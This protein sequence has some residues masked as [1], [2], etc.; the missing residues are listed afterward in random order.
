MPKPSNDYQLKL[1][2]QKNLLCQIFN[3][4][5]I[6]VRHLRGAQVM[7][8]DKMVLVVLDEV[9]NWWQLEEMANQRGWVGPGSIIIITTEDRKLLTTF[10]LGINQIYRM[11][12]PTRDES[13]KIFCQYAFGQK[14]PDNGFESL[15]WEVSRLAG[16][17]P[18]G[19]RVMGSYLRGMSRDGWIQALPWLR[20][21]PDREIE[22]T[23]RFSYDALRENEKTLFLHLAC[24]FTGFDVYRFKSYFAKSSLEV[25]HGL[26]VLAQ[27]SLISIETGSIRMHRLLQQMGREIVKKRCLEN[28]GNPHF[29]TD[30]K[31]ISDVLE[32]DTATGNVLGIMLRTNKKILINKSTFQGRIN[33]QFLY[34]DSTT[35]S[36]P[37]GLDCL[38]RKIVLLYWKK[39]PLRVWPSKFSGKFLVELIMQYSKFEMLWEGTKPFPY[40]K[41]LD[42]SFSMNLKK[43]PNLSE[44][45]SL[46]DLRL[47]KCKSLLELTSSI[48]NATKL[49][50][51][52][53]TECTKISDFP[54][55]CDSIE[56]LIL[57]FTGIKEVPPWIENLRSLRK[58]IMFGCGNLETISPNISKLENLEFLG[59]SSSGYCSLDN[60]VSHNEYGDEDHYELDWFELFEAIIEWGPDFMR[61]WR[62]RSN[63]NVHDILP[64][65]LPQKARTSPIS[66]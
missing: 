7:L 14:F 16:K 59:M 33:L 20:S 41:K 11:K 32:E 48:G 4:R 21:T 9:D 34:F 65:C 15:A 1:L 38:P 18:L 39:C 50:R 36:T 42:F 28:P 19:L 12:Y 30:T 24:F 23:L 49:Y 46:E 61:S 57:C 26:E 52:V 6:E 43:L 62:L 55:V 54:N 35:I 44:A 66:L 5:D 29:L 8:S 10:G 13:L 25:N 60:H 37:E 64:I 40:L 31:E 3:K 51:L 45:T 63:L 2:L 27:K 58:L 47:N 17:L 22:S 53:I 56:E